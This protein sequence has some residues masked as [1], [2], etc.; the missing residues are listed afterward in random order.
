ML[1]TFLGPATL[2]NL[3]IGHRA[4]LSRQCDVDRLPSASRNNVE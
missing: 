1:E 2:D 4:I 3:V